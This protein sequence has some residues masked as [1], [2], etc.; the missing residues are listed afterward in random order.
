MAKQFNEVVEPAKKLTREYGEVEQGRAER[1]PLAD[2]GVP[3]RGG[4]FFAVLALAAGILGFVGLSGT[5]A[6][7]AKALLLVF[8]VLFVLSLVFGRRRGSAV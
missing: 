3:P 4:E 8:V 1:V 5:L 6:W 7:I 2:V